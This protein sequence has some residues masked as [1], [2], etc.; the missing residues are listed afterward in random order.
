MILCKNTLEKLRKI[1]N[2]DGKDDYR[3]GPKLVSFF[4]ELGFNDSYGQGFP[5]R[6]IFTDHKLEKLMEHRK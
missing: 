2:G 1:I 5:S 3:S 6:W 4:N